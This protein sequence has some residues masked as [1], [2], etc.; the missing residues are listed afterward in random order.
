MSKEVKEENGTKKVTFLLSKEAR[1]NVESVQ[2]WMQVAVGF[3]PSLTEILNRAVQDFNAAR[4][5]SNVKKRIN[6]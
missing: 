5:I 6:A 4:F 2:D 3:S 1:E